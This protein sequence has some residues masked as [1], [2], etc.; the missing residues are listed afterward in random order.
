ML[1]FSLHISVFE[2][3]FGALNN[4][5]CVFIHTGLGQLWCESLLHKVSCI[6]FVKSTE[7]LFQSILLQVSLVEVVKHARNRIELYHWLV[8]RRIQVLYRRHNLHLLHLLYPATL[9]KLLEDV[10]RFLICR[11]VLHL[12]GGHHFRGYSATVDWHLVATTNQIFVFLQGMDQ[13]LNCET[14]VSHLPRA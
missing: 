8:V 9:N 5:S 6:L 1:D 10:T 12:L 13:R 2:G 14:V 4:I 7:D 11:Q 3:I